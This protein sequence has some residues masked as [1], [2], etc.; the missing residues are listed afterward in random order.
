MF[1]DSGQYFDERGLA[2][3]VFSRYLSQQGI[4]CSIAHTKA[5]IDQAREAVEAGATLVTHL[6]DV[7]EI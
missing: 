5:T 4:V 2:R 6:Y 7:F 3:T 1:L